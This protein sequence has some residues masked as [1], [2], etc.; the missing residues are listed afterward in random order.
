MWYTQS[1]AKRTRAAFHERS[2]VLPAKAH[3]PNKTTRAA[4][5]EKS[6]PLLVYAHNAA[7]TTRATLHEKWKAFPAM[8]PNA[9]KTKRGA[10]HE[11][12][13]VLAATVHNA[14]RAS[15]ET[16]RGNLNRILVTTD[17]IIVVSLLP[18]ACFNYIT[19]SQTSVDYR[20]AVFKYGRNRCFVALRWP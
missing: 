14:K 20:L 16:C 7:E 5:H 9:K 11:R 10:F 12:L 15:A 8:A 6:K 2:K 4:F 1:S 18:S 13:K 19:F 3:S 17:L